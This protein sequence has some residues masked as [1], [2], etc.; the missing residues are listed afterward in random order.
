[1]A[2]KKDPSWHRMMR[3]WQ[4]L[5]EG[6]RVLLEQEPDE[7]EDEEGS[8]DEED[9]PE[10]PEPDP[11]PEPELEPLPGTA[12]EDSLDN[13]IDAILIGFEKDSVEQQNEWSGLSRKSHFRSMMAERRRRKGRTL[14][15]AFGNLLEAE[16]DEDEDEVTTDNT[17]P[18]NVSAEDPSRPPLNLDHFAQ[19]VARLVNNYETM[20][21]VPASIIDRATRFIEDNYDRETADQ[22]EEI[23]ATQHDI[24]SQE[25]PEEYPA[26][27]PPAYGA[28]GVPSA[29]GGLGGGGGGEL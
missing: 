27:G 15:E 19:R 23:L 5:S 21:D 24:E 9:E 6:R 17:E 13:Q 18:E 1:M 25:D 28:E 8:G 3:D 2:P 16:G 20:L 10:V 26:Y 4:L 7:E 11:D 12:S 14:W 29:T 22:F